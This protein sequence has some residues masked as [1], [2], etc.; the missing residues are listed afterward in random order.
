MPRTPIRIPLAI[1]LGLG[2]LAPWPSWA[3]ESGS[4]AAM[5]HEVGGVTRTITLGGYSLEVDER[6]VEDPD[7][8]RWLPAIV[9]S[10]QAEAAA[11]IY[12]TVNGT[13]VRYD[14]FLGSE[15]LSFE[16][17]LAFR[18]STEQLLPDTVDGVVAQV[19]DTNTNGRL[20]RRE[21]VKGNRA[22]KRF[23]CSRIRAAVQPGAGY[24][25]LA[26][27]QDITTFSGAWLDHQARMAAEDP[28]DCPDCAG[29]PH[30][31][32]LAALVGYLQ[33]YAPPMEGSH[34]SLFVPGYNQVFV[35]VDTHVTREGM[36][37]LD[38]ADGRSYWDMG[39]LPHGDA[40]LDGNVDLVTSAQEFPSSSY[41]E[42]T[43]RWERYQPGPGNQWMYEVLVDLAH[44]HLPRR[45]QVA[46]AMELEPEIVVPAWFEDELSAQ[47]FV[48]AEAQPPVCP[49]V[50]KT[51]PAKQ[52]N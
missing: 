24:A 13:K 40:A 48:S 36:L 5:W 21:L 35:T 49:Q 6:I 32:K 42:V 26:P 11:W 16:R 10:P 15:R 44:A 19:Y 27:L 39:H 31:D 45:M 33:E 51:P 25:A 46:E 43:Q 30:L 9:P 34:T 2:V 38:A 18:I 14:E 41:N 28:W 1:L 52:Q 47:P 12:R 17:S 29:I 7:M 37:R 22:M 8:D 3:T 23:F 50:F 20:S 4:E